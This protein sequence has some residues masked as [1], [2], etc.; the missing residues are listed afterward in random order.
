MGW[1]RNS[2]RNKRLTGMF[3]WCFTDPTKFVLALCQK[4]T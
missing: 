2:N 4:R 1:E 3:S